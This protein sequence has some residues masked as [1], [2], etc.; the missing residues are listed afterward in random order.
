M[1][2][3]KNTLTVG[4]DG[5]FRRSRFGDFLIMVL[6]RD[7]FAAPQN[8]DLDKRL[9]YNYA[10][11]SIQLCPKEVFINSPFNSQALSTINL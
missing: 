10:D 11:L 3:V 8:N 4:W 9:P 5:A 1:L 7:L 6:T 2:R